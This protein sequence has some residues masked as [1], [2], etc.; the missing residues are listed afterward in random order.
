[1]SLLI[2]YGIMF[3]TLNI[4]TLI[5]KLSDIMSNFNSKFSYTLAEVNLTSIPVF[6]TSV[7]VFRTSVNLIF[8]K[9]QQ[10]EPPD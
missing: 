7:P 1:M 4:E 9:Q 3:T 10:H 5:C 8:C 6:Y 2:W